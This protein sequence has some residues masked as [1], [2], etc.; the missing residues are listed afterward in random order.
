MFNAWFGFVAPAGTPDDIV[1][2]I[3]D[4]VVRQAETPGFQEAMAKAGLEPI[5][6]SPAD[7]AKVIDA[8]LGN[9]A[10]VLSQ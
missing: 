6:D 1:A 2:K 4:E 3:D 10:I 7:F 8:E 9:W 5:V